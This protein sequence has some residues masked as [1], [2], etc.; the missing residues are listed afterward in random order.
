MESTNYP[1]MSCSGILVNKLIF[2]NSPSFIYFQINKG[3]NVKWSQNIKLNDTEYRLSGFIYFA[4]FHFTTRVIT[5]TGDIWF[6]DSMDEV[7]QQSHFEGNIED[8]SSRK[9]TKDP[10]ERP[11]SI[12]IYTI[13]L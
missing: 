1:C 10:K 7:Y 6:I 2:T 5:A 11:L 9:L 12:V 8:I 4:N 13:K 3:I